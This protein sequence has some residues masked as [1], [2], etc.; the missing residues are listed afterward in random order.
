[1][2]LFNIHTISKAKESI[3][4]IDCM[5]IDFFCLVFSEKCRNKNKERGSWKVKVCNEFIHKKKGFTRSDVEKAL[6][7]K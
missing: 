4:F 1:M 3:F 5:V 6:K 2:T 7:N